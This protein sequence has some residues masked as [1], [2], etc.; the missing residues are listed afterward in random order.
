VAFV[1]PAIRSVLDLGC[2]EGQLGLTFQEVY[3]RARL[4][5]LDRDSAA[6]EK[7]RDAPKP[8]IGTTEFVVGDMEHGVPEGPFDL[9]YAS[10][11]LSHTRN[12]VGMIPML[13]EA[14]APGGYLWIKDLGP[15]MEQVG[16]HP[17][18]Q[19]LVQLTFSA[20]AALGAHMQV[21]EE[22][23]PH[24]LAAGF[25]E[26]RHETES[27][28]LGG[29]SLAGQAILVNM[30]A[31]CYSAQMATQKVHK[32]ADNEIRTLC[33]AISNDAYQRTED[34]GTC[35]FTNLIVRRPAA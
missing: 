29:A 12:P 28:P 14:L 22:L 34:L 20:L 6:I 35:P 27:Y 17:A 32:L 24:L 25:T 8:G 7:A 18:Y 4:V 26:V 9:I 21:V 16:T 10:L 2:G 13:Y 33:F 5:G 30:L 23:R 19:K 31:V 3:P 15:N 1:G 11:S